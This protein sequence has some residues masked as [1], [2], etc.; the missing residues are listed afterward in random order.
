MNDIRRAYSEVSAILDLLDDEYIS[1]VP[2]KF[3]EFIDNEKDNEYFININPNV[4]LEKQELLPDTIN[5]LAMLKLDYWCDTEEEK[6]ELLNILN[7]NEEEYQEQLRE[8]Y[9]PENLFKNNDKNKE[10]KSLTIIEEKSFIIKIF[11]KIKSMFK[12]I[13][14]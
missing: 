3:I 9:N 7:K 5:I 4:P 10:E 14:K 2:R 6:L 11:E 1:K 13:Q 12:K 8:K